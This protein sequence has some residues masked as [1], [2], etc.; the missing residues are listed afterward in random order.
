[1]RIKCPECKSALSLGEPKPGKYRPKCKHCGQSFRI[2][3]TEDDPPRAKLLRDKPEESEEEAARRR[4]R[5]AERKARRAEK[6]ARAAKQEKQPVAAEAPAATTSPRR[7]PVAVG[8]SQPDLSDGTRSEQRSGSVDATMDSADTQSPASSSTEIEATMDSVD[9]RSQSRPG[10]V[11]AAETTLDESIAPPGKATDASLHATM[12]TAVGT[13]GADKTAG[14]EE[15]T[16]AGTV[17]P[18][19]HEGES[20]PVVSRGGKSQSDAKVSAGAAGHGQADDHDIPEKLG[21]YRILRLLGRG[22]MGAVYEAKQISLDRLVALKTIRARLAGNASSLARFTREAYAAAQLTH[23]NVVQIY[24]FGEDDGKHFFS[25]EWVRGGPLSELVQEKGVLD[26]RLAAGYTLQAARGLQFAHGS[27]MVH[28][29]VK[30]ANLLLS[31]EGV[32]K[33]ADLGLVKIPDQMDPE[34]DVG[35]TSTTSGVASGTEVT[36]QG[37][38]VGT[39]AYMAPEQGVDAAGVDHRADIYSLG[40][41]LFFLLSGKPPF[42]GNQISEVLEYHASKPLPDLSAINSRV[43]PTLQ[44]ICERA[45]A[46]KPEDRYES[47]AQ[48]ITE[49][50]GFLGV[51][52]EG[53]FSPSSGQADRWEEIAA[54]YSSSTPL[55]RLT[56]TL[57]MAFVGC[58]GLLTIVMP[59]LQMSLLLTGPTALI[60]G[61]VTALMLGATGGKSAVVNHFRRWVGSLSWFDYGVGV[62]GGIIFLLVTVLAGLVIGLVVGLV[63]GAVVGAGFH[64]A[65]VAPTRRMSAN[66][67]RDAERFIRDLR[68]KG[69][70][71]DGVRMFA[72][73]YA[74]KRWQGL[75]ERLFGYESMCE[76]RKQL[77][78]DPSFSGSTQTTLRDRLCERL[79]CKADANREA[80]DHKRLA[81]IEER[82]LQSEGLSAGDARERAWQMA[83]AVMDNAKLQA[84][85]DRN[86]DADAAAV[87]AA[88]KRARMKAMLADARSGK[89]KKKRDKLAMV[90]FVLGGQTRLLAGTLLLAI[91]AIWAHQIGLLEQVKTVAQNAAAQGSLDSG[92]VDQIR[93]TA[94]E[95]DSDSGMNWSIGIA[96]LLLCMSAF[97]SGWRMTP[98]ALIATLVIL[99]GKSFGVPG[100]A[101]LEPWMV[102]ALAGI[103]VYLPGVVFGETKEFE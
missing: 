84:V 20:K 4:A 95:V 18:S 99:F 101:F 21:G 58:C 40:C 41:T 42:E 93:Q 36:M 25:M 77:A 69:A 28:R 80:R 39:P 33:V 10:S 87:A 46:K 85:A 59:L 68:I 76:V 47:L 94:A 96:G 92:A 5:R 32:V 79:A 70:D 78:N 56:P 23:H 22:A 89:Y 26:P 91:F 71:E 8:P 63:I 75:F 62:F 14:V 52:Q 27:G 19:A 31:D 1:M 83:A 67:L 7:V 88:A 73:R 97:V 43:S 34:S 74:G 66:S 51:S 35:A 90:W 45:T 49:L 12:D 81:K 17:E 65:I 61:L 48:M 55:T 11:A 72:A 64:F 103:V 54:S 30:P 6:E 60:S 13:R 3:I 15:A 98:F 38:A 44:R 82:G 24:D 86:A 2:K 29:D 102:A 37:T 50:E 53:K 100:V 57:L 16:M 9:R